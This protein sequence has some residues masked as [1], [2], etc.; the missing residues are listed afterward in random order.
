MKKNLVIPIAAFLLL[1]ILS[2]FQCSSTELTSAKLYI[3]QKQ[4]DKAL[5]ILDKE[6]QKNPKSHEGHYLKGY[7]YNEQGNY[8]EMLEAF[9][10]SLA[11][12]PEFKEDIEKIKTIAWS[13]AYNKGVGFYNKPDYEQAAKAFN[14]AILLRPDS[15]STYRTLAITYIQSKQIDKAVSTLEEQLKHEK[16]NETVALLGELILSQG[17]EMAQKGDTLKAAEQ[18]NK[19]I[20]ILSEGT[21]LYPA[22]SNILIMLAQAYIFSGKT[23]VAMET[24]KA[25][26]EK[27]PDNEVNQYNYGVLLLEA[28]KYEE[29]INSFKKAIELKPDYEN[30][31]YNIA[32]C[33]V[34]LGAQISKTSTDASSGT[35]YKEKY[36]TAL[37]YLEKVLQMNP[38]DIRAWDTIAKVYAA[39]GML[40]E[41]EEA[42]KKVDEYSKAQ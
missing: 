33:Y 18:F 38:K 32:V 39:L 15:V 21:K 11:I 6:I 36:K 28:E 9:D 22:D 27:N 41:S 25:L 34:R 2:A 3:Q 42:Y 8:K 37:P 40:K 4:F 12:S 19:A 13:N 5:E 26:A 23:E 29:A 16:N 14:D 17:N 7:V 30:A 31:L 10:K 20:G 35:E 1:I 24:F